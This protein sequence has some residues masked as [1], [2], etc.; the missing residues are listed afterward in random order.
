VSGRADRIYLTG[1]MGCGKS[2]LAPPLAAALGYAVVDLDAEVEG[3]EGMTITEIFSRHGEAYF[4]RAERDLLGRISGRERIVAALG[5]GTVANR[6]NLALVKSTGIMIWLRTDPE[7]LQGRLRGKTDRPMLGV[8]AE[9]AATDAMMAL[10]LERTP[11][12]EEADLVVDTDGVPATLE[13]LTSALDEY[14]RT[15]RA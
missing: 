9:D 14:R 6:D 10:L 11:W 12:Y 2:T 8:A 13:R 15:Q 7:V 5:G 1:F 3:R 4:R